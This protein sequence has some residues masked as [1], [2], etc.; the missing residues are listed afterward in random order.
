MTDRE[1]KSALRIG[2]QMWLIFF[3]SLLLL[4]IAWILPRP[5]GAAPPDLPRTA[6]LC[7]GGYAIWANNP[8]REKTIKWPGSK[9]AVNGNVYSN[10]SIKISGSNNLV[11]GAGEY[12]STFV[13]SG[14]SN[15]YPFPTQVAPGP[16]P[17]S[18]TINNSRPGGAVANT[19]QAA[20]KYRIVVGNLKVSTKNT[21]LDGLYYVTADYCASLSAAVTNTFCLAKAILP[22][23]GCSKMASLTYN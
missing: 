6:N 23:N 22:S 13:D 17:V 14:K 10:R 2:R 9:S 21:A 16:L 11:T 15:S 1:F 8:T 5:V 7:S 12:V 3:L 4:F 19:V 18:Y 20:G